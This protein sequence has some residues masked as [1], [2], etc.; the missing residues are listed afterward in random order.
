VAV[1]D[2]NT[3]PASQSGATGGL[4]LSDWIVGGHVPK[5]GRR[6]PMKEPSIIVCEPRLRDQFNNVR[7]YPS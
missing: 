3:D 5:G 2:G 6:R 1:T 4:D 7:I